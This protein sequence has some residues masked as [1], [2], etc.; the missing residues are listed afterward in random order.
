MIKGM[1]FDFD[2]TLFDSMPFW[3]RLPFD[4]LR[5]Q[6]IE[7]AD[8]I[9]ETVKTLTLPQAAEY[10]IHQYDLPKDVPQ[11]MQETAQ[12]IMDMYRYQILPKPCVPQLLETLS[13]HDVRMCIATA[14]DRPMIEAALK[15]TGLDRYFSAIFTC[16]ETGSPKTESKIYEEARAALG[17]DRQRTAVAEDAFHAAKTAR[18]AGFTVIGIRDASEQQ[19]EE[20][21]AVCDLYLSGFDEPGAFGKILEL[22]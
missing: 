17:T 7:P 19:Q 13:H 15:R 20:L 21:K 18:E 4:Y 11:I 10:F 2:G 5:R 8:D 6:G 9:F 12:M 3:Y 14:T 22:L 16:T 1:I